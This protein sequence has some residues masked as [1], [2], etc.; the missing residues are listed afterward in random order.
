MVFEL[1]KS[2]FRPSPI[3][4]A[5]KHCLGADHFLMVSVMTFHESYKTVGIE[6]P[7]DES[8]FNGLEEILKSC[9]TENK[10]LTL[11][12]VSAFLGCVIR[13]QLGGKWVKTNDGRY[14]ITGIGRNNSTVDLEDDIKSHLEKDIR[15]S[16]KELYHKIEITN[17]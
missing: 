8:S 3:D 2:F 1:I 15:P 5:F 6:L 10:N 17:R 14:K 4:K 16:V 9:D 11:F 13:E 12:A 7:P